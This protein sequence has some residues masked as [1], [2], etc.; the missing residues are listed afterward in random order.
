MGGDFK[1]GS[2]MFMMC[3][4]VIGAVLLYSLFLMRKAWRRG[5]EIG[6]TTE[7][8]KKVVINSSLVSIVP[9]LPVIISLFVLMKGLGRYFAWLRLSVIGAVSYETMVATQVAESYGL[10]S[11]ADPL[12]T[13]DV[14]ISA[15]WAM[16]LSI[17]AGIIFCIFFMGPIDRK[18][19]LETSSGKSKNMNRY[20]ASLFPAL[21]TTFIVPI[22]FNTADSNGIIALIASCII[23]LLLAVISKKSGKK[24]FSEF[25]LPL[26][27]LGGMAAV[28]IINMI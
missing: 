3:A 16:T 27:L 24:V 1:N 21:M 5:K 26:G 7:T 9:T 10:A 20:L 8:M 13:G 23:A 14:F 4:L 28:I 19:K 11:I 18:F 2:L 17:S 15:M 25:A 6:M 22:V 12:F